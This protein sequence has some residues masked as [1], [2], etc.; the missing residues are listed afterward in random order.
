MI[1]ITV[2]CIFDV[3]IFLW[4]NKQFDKKALYKFKSVI[5][6]ICMVMITNF[7]NREEVNHLLIRVI[8]NFL[9][10]FIWF[11]IIYAENATKKKL[12]RTFCIC[13]C[14]MLSEISISIILMVAA[15]NTNLDILLNDS[16]F[17][18][19]SLFT[20]K[21]CEIIYLNLINK[22]DNRLKNM[23]ISWHIMGI[24]AILGYLYF[25]VYCF[26]RKRIDYT[27][28]GI[29]FIVNILFVLIIFCGYFI[30]LNIVNKAR[31]QEEEI[32]LLSEK[33]KVQ[34]ECYEEINNYKKQMQKTYHDLKN[35]VL[36][37]ENLNSNETKE[38]YIN[39]LEE[40]FNR[41]PIK[42]NS[43]NEIL[44]ILIQKKYE[45][46]RGKNI[47]LNFYINFKKG[48]FI[49]LVDVGIIF[50]N[51]IDNAIEACERTQL[52][53]KNINLIVNEHEDFIVINIV[54]PAIKII[55]RGGRLITMKKEK[56]NHGIG[57]VCLEDALK[58]YNGTFSYEIKKNNFALTILIPIKH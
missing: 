9:F 30:F 51:I 27:V 4:F 6:F 29:A 10:Y 42:V 1:K 49:N 5:Y 48:D 26:L 2:S 25:I 13:G 57:L 19:I 50:G 46:C 11:Q 7:M 39:S 34:I 40:Y 33:T 52:F 38:K 16:I 41:R 43:G 31:E 36:I 47:N 37:A 3:G 15:K 20:A 18:L 17:W 21:S 58:K 28:L 45:E 14:A 56:K 12:I 35:Q 54:N 8:V 44:D 55:E 24:C 22:V 23:H 32:K 53:K